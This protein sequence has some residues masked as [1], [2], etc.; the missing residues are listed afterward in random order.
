M[1]GIVDEE[2][3]KIDALLAACYIS[4]YE[5]DTR[6]K[7]I[8][9]QHH[10]NIDPTNKYSA[11]QP[12]NDD[13]SEEYDV[14]FTDDDNR[15]YNVDNSY[16]NSNSSYFNDN[17][18]SGFTNNDDYSNYY[19]STTYG[20]STY[21]PS[22]YS[23][24]TPTPTPMEE[25]EKEIPVLTHD[26]EKNLDLDDNY[27]NNNNNNNNYN[28]KVAAKT[29]PKNNNNNNNNN[30]R[31]NNN[32][33]NNNNKSTTT[34]TTNNNNN[35]APTFLSM[36]TNPKPVAAEPKP[37]AAEAPTFL[38]MFMNSKP[39]AAAQPKPVVVAPAVV[40]KN[41]ETTTIYNNGK[42]IVFKANAPDS[43]LQVD[44]SN[45]TKERDNNGRPTE[46]FGQAMINQKNIWKNE[47]IQLL[48]KLDKTNR[49]K[50]LPNGQL[51]IKYVAGSDISFAKGNKIDAC[52]SIVVMEYPSLKVVYESYKMIKLTQPYIAGYLAMREVDH[53]VALWQSLKRTHP[54][55]T[56]DIMVVDGNGVNHMRGMG[57]ACHLGILIDCP[58]LGVAKNLLVCHGITEEYL[59][60]QFDYATLG[61][62]VQMKSDQTNELLGYCTYNNENERLYIS[63]G[64]KI[65]AYTALQV[66]EQ[67]TK[68]HNLPEPTYIAD[69]YSR[70]FL[71][72]YYKLFKA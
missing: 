20:G 55:F 24:P 49:V 56:P 59:D 71:R 30:K 11:Q 40:S 64:H 9:A 15:T 13:Q 50:K 52:A 25:E 19:G 29:A 35:N 67:T 45:W 12:S 21:N 37:V 66:Y 72:I 10:A 32:T 42:S 23:T 58:T 14:S 46:L 38:S 27:N 3:Q 2:I 68:T 48:S 43:T 6:K 39:A 51:N 65:D 54:Q 5:Y 36:F 18:P 4:Q 62:A 47:Q 33:N 60:E 70:E 41:Y 63:P 17:A 34:T 53:L 57:L 7:D 44:L 16:N 26:F 22:T 31:N 28:T 1:T 61:E 69:H 8:L